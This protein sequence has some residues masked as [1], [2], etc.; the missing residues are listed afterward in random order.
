M[1][2][3]VPNATTAVPLTAAAVARDVVDRSGLA[4]A[5]PHAKTRR[6]T[7]DNDR[8]VNRTYAFNAAGATKPAV[9]L[10]LSLRTR[11]A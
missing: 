6:A 11:D 7:T 9:R 8:D 2:D 3:D 10:R 5:G 1:S 4:K